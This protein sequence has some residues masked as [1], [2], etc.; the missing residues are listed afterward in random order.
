MK[1]NANS[2]DIAMIM[3][4]LRRNGATPKPSVGWPKPGSTRLHLTCL[5]HQES[6]ARERAVFSSEVALACLRVYGTGFKTLLQ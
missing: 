6:R 4:R 5:G 3:I 1:F 2:R